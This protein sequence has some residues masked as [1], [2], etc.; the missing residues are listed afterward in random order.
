MKIVVRAQLVTDWGEITEVDVAEF[1][2]PRSHSM[3][4]RWACHWPTARR[5]Y[6]NYKR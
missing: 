5:S 1:C 6:S 4:I 3:R 2:G